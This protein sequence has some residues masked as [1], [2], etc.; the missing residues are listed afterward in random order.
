MPSYNCSLREE[1]KFCG[2]KA[3]VCPLPV[4]GGATASAA[5]QWRFH[6]D[7]MQLGEPLARGVGGADL[8]EGGGD[9]LHGGKGPGLGG[10]CGLPSGEHLGGLLLKTLGAE[11]GLQLQCS[12]LL[13]AD[14]LSQADGSRLPRQRRDQVL[15]CPN[16]AHAHHRRVCVLLPRGP[17]WQD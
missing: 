12:L 6:A 10:V 13:A 2:T 5:I 8:L 3:A 9:A 1:L 4:P 15:R 17:T 7:S 16:P 14:Q 11:V